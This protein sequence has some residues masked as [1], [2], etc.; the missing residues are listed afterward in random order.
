MICGPTLLGKTTFIRHQL[1]FAGLSHGYF[2][3]DWAL[4]EWDNSVD[5]IVFDDVIFEFIKGR[6]QFWGCQR[7]FIIDDKFR[8]KR[9]I[10]GGIPMIFLCNNEEDFE[11]A[12]K[13]K[14]GGFVLQG[15]EFDWYRQNTIRV[16]VIN[17]MYIE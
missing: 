1:H 15:T 8:T 13:K 5:V 11:V 9:R 10:E 17:K 14:D 16:D 2:Q 12:R 4:D 7:D 6:K 3:R